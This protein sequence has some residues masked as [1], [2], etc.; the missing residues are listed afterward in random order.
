MAY[1]NELILGWPFAQWDRLTDLNLPVCSTVKTKPTM[2]IAVAGESLEDEDYEDVDVG[3]LYEQ[4]QPCLIKFN[5]PLI[6]SHL[7]ALE[8]VGFEILRAKNKTGYVD[9]KTSLGKREFSPW[10][11]ELFYDPHE[12]GEEAEHAVIGVAI[13]GRYFPTFADWKG[14][15]GT[16][17]PIIFDD[18]LQLMQGI[19]KRHITSVL[20]CLKN[21]PWIVKEIH[22]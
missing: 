8:D 5:E 2:R 17:S 18:E 1:G 16:L 21:A 9:A 22:Y 20:P 4:I 12:M 11:L 6:L 15:H 13:S 7:N 19:A 14:S 3:D 10:T